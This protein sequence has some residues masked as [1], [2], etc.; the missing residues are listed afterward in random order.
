MTDSNEGQQTTDNADVESEESSPEAP[1]D[2]QGDSEEKDRSGDDIDYK[3]QLKEERKR[4]KQAE[5]NIVQLKQEQKGSEEKEDTPKSDDSGDAS[6]GDIDEATIRSMIQEKVNEVKQEATSGTV[7]EVLNSMASSQDEKELI[8]HHYENTI[9]Q[10]GYSREDVQRDIQRAKLL[11]NES[12]LR[13][14]LQETAQALQSERSKNRAG[15][16]SP[17]RSGSDDERANASLTNDEEKLAE[18][19]AR[20]NEDMSLEEA[21]KALM[22]AKQAGEGAVA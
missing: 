16:L 17:Q 14:Q 8:Q 18:R 1:S 9:N 2:N 13:T 21:R 11:A 20:R 12:N 10:S 19:R 3:A 5:H 4:R 7:D 22:E 6:S 15:G